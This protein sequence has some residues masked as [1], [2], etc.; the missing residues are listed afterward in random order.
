[1]S[2]E[3]SLEEQIKELKKAVES[4]VEIQKMQIQ[5]QVSKPSNT[6]VKEDQPSREEIEEMLREYDVAELLHYALKHDLIKRGRE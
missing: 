2:E 3:K 1:M 6:E 5:Q 4:L